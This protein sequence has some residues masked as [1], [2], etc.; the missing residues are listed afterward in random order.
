MAMSRS[1][2]LNVFLLQLN[3][4]YIGI[5]DQHPGEGVEAAGALLSLGVLLRL[6]RGVL[7]LLPA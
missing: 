5:S 3:P 6:L 1:F 2:S 7:L 4:L